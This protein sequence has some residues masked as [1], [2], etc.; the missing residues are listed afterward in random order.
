[1]RPRITALYLVRDEMEFLPMSIETVREHVERIVIV[2]NESSDGTDKWA[3]QLEI[4]NPHLVRFHRMEG[5]F[6]KSTEFGNRNRALQ[7]VTDA[8]WVLVLDGD[9]LL[10][11]GWRQYIKKPLDAASGYDA[12]R[13]RY[14]HLVGSYEH[15]HTE[16]YEKQNGLKEHP[17]VPLWQTVL[18]RA[19]SWLE[20]KPACLADKR[21]KEFHHSSYDPSM[22]GRR[23][24]NCGQAT[25]FHYGFSKRNMM[26]MAKYRIHRGDYGHEPERKEKMWK[27]LDKCGNPFKYIGPVIRVAYGP[28]HVPTVLRKKFGNTYKLELD[29]DGFIQSRTLIETGEKC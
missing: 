16:F 7:Y 3:E 21:F 19:G 17:D 18:F 26:H 14:D 5:I 4:D 8:D 23:F 24:Y 20:A 2:D 29:K 25:C 15:T 12:I 28:E 9:Q 11:D 6:D 1:M 22:V 10:S 13:F 27:E